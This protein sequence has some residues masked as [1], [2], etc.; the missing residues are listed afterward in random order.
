MEELLNALNSNNED[1]VN[2]LACAMFIT[3]EGKAVREKIREF[4][5]YSG[6]HIF[7]AEKASD[8]F[9][10]GWIRYNQKTFYYEKISQNLH[11]I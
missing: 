6:C 11:S 5:D 1:L 10:L 3:K 2:D 4:E 7:P 9:I 8:G